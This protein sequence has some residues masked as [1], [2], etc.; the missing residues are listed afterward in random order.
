MYACTG[1]GNEY[2]LQHRDGTLFVQHIPKRKVS[3]VGSI[4]H[5]I[6]DLACPDK[7]DLH[8]ATLGRLEVGGRR[9]TVISE[10]DGFDVATGRSVELKARKDKGRMPAPQQ[11]KKKRGKGYR[12]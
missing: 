10:V 3:D 4:G 1:E 9:L 2:L 11:C 7:S 8:H 6:E 12:A 5:V